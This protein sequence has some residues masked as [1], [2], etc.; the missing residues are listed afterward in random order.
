VSILVEDPQG[1]DE[2]LGSLVFES[3]YDKGG[4]FAAWER[5]DAIAGDLQKMFGNGGPCF[6]IVPGK[7]GY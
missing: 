2:C 3:E 7:S 6:S 1:A 4:H 5:P